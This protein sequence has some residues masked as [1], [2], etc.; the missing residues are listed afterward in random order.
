MGV[1]CK[2]SSVR[3]ACGYKEL[4]WGLRLELGGSQTGLNGF[5][6]LDSKR[7]DVSL[8]KKKVETLQTDQ[9][10]H[11]CATKCATATFG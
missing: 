11:G 3:K 4:R 2:N 6:A 5:G 7:A 10:K 8:N 9:P 1:W